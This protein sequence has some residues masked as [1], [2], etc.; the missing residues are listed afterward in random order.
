MMLDAD[1]FAALASLL[2]EPTAAARQA[3]A[4]T[5]AGTAREPGTRR[6]NLRAATVADDRSGRHVAPLVS[7]PDRA[8]ATT[9]GR[10]PT[11]LQLELPYTR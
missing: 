10:A 2:H 8:P 4:G 3:Q 9:L 5:S 1:E 6:R 7:A 11:W